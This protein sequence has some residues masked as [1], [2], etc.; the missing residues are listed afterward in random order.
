MEDE[1]DSTNVQVQETVEGLRTQLAAMEA[2]I[3]GPMSSSLFPPKTFS[4]LGYDDV[5]DFITKFECYCIFYNWSNAKKLATISLLFEGPALA[6]YQTVA[7][8]TKNNYKNLIDAL[9]GGLLQ[10]VH[11]SCRDKN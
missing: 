2:A 1:Q 5:T 9:H 11:S 6:W 4:D 8:E 3:K 10:L 7:N